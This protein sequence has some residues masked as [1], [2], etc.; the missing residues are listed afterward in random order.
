MARE[1]AVVPHTHWDREW[2]EPFEAYRMRLA[3]V[4]DGLLQ[5]MGTGE[6]PPHFHL[7]GQVA[8]LD[9]Y[10]AIR[11]AAEAR[12]ADLVGSGR[13]AVGPWYVLMDEFCVSAETIVRN[14]ELGLARG[15]RFGADR[16]GACRPVGYLPDMFGHIAQM[17]QML[18]QAGID[19]AVVWRGVPA[20]IG[21]HS[22]D[23]VAPDGSRVRAEY[24]PVGYAAGAFLPKD[25]P[26]LVRRMEAHERE[27]ASFYRDDEAILLMNGGDHQAPQAW[28]TRL[29]SD[30]NAG[31]DRFRF[32]ATSLAGYLSSGAR[33]GGEWM[34][35]LRSG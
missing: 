27:I 22:F 25:G 29:L 18:R 21:C 26:S 13:L 3:G 23:W 7:D 16:P 4:V 6:A 11:P 8:V 35:E 15:R 34:G 2:Y 33:A 10:V 28:L 12:L 19:E 30:A 32:V 20:A 17:P 31:N 5:L 14:L 24:L 9:D 1:V